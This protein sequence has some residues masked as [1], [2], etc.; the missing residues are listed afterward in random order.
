MDKQEHKMNNVGDL[1]IELNAR[2]V[3]III[4]PMCVSTSLY[5]T[6]GILT[7]LKNART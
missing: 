2:L 7:I 5:R 1:I 4:L 6:A 3:N